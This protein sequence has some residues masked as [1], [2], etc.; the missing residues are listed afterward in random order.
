MDSQRPL[1][2]ARYDRRMDPAALVST[3]IGA[4]VGRAQLAV[5]AKLLQ[6]DAANEQS[7][8]GLIDAAQQNMDRLANVAA[9]IGG[10]LDISV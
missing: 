10:N 7:V 2:G 3:L 9:G 8:V 6:M 1:T 4:Q 5:A